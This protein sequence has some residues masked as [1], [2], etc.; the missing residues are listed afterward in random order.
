MKKISEDLLNEPYLQDVTGWET[1]DFPD[2]RC[3]ELEDENR[4][5]K[6]ELDGLHKELC[7]KDDQ[8]YALTE[9]KE[10]EG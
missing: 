9:G 2:C 10:G 1:E 8:I 5:L 3:D 6:E 7:A 4:R